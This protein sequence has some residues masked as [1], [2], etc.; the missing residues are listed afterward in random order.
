MAVV[1]KHDTSHGVQEHLEH[2]LG[3]QAGPDYVGDANNQT[4]WSEK[5]GPSTGG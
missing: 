1:R 4:L 5:G 3:A 2:G